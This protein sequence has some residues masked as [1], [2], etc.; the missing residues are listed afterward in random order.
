MKKHKTYLLGLNY[1]ERVL[2]RNAMITSHHA[3]GTPFIPEPGRQT[4]NA[5]TRLAAWGYL[6]VVDPEYLLVV[7]TR[8][9]LMK[10][11]RDM[12]AMIAKEA[13]L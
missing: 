9:N 8:K 4:A 5:V 7:V 1:Y 3:P 13:A 6:T 2:I 12:K 10:F 11:R